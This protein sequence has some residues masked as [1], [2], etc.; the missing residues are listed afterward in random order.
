MTCLLGKPSSE[1]DCLVGAQVQITVG[2]PLGGLG[3]KFKCWVGFDSWF[4]NTYEL[5]MCW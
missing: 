3:C 4:D 1:G 5:H 2:G